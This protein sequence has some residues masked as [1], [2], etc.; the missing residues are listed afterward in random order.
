L[1]IHHNQDMR[2]TLMKFPQRAPFSERPLTANTQSLLFKSSK[3]KTKSMEMQN[4]PKI[5]N[6]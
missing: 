1:Q 2:N 6:H 3:P 4:P 5:F